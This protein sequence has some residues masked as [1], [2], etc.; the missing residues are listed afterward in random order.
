MNG[1][2]QTPLDNKT[3]PINVPGLGDIPVNVLLSHDQF[4]TGT[5]DWKGPI[6]TAKELAMLDL[7]N[8]ITDRPGWHRAIFDQQTIAQWREDAMSS[9][10]LINDNT[11]AWCLQ[12]LQD[13]ARQFDRDGR[14][15][16]FNTSSGVCKSDTVISSELGSKLLNS[17]DL[18]S[19]QTIRQKSDSA[20]VNLVDP[21]LFPLV[22]GRTKILVGGQSCGL[23]EKAWSSCT[24]EDLVVSEVP[25]LVKEGS[26][27]SWGGGR[28]IWSSKF[29]WLPCEVQ[30]T[31]PCGSS[32]VRISSYINNLHPENRECYAAIEAVISSSIKQWNEI[33]VRNKWR[34]AIGSFHGNCDHCPWEAMR[35]RTYGVE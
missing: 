13:K 24:T 10:S 14:L 27:W 20:M 15:V 30:F 21:S 29:Q 8:T 12:E 32:D 9:S 22:Y 28:Y 23:D 3:S 1:I 6:L 11:W 35:I 2:I 26:N 4:A 31:G 25:Q 33:V 34:R 19:H 18:L 17:V 7:I 16:V 5:N